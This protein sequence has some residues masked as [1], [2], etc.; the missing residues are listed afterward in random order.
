MVLA[1]ISRTRWAALGAAVAVSLGAGGIG[2]VDAA[3]G[4]GERTVFVPITPCRL[5]DTRPEFQVGS[6]NTPLGPDETY[7][8]AGLGA[9]GE[10][11]LPADAAGLV[12]NVTTVDA[13]LPTFVSVWPAGQPQPNASHLNPA[14]GEPP[15]PNAVTTD[16]GASGEFSVYNKQGSVHLF[17]DAVG[18][19]VDHHHDDRYYTKA[20]VYTQA[21]VDA[22]TAPEP[23]L[24][25]HPHI[26]DF[27]TPDTGTAQEAWHLGNGWEHTAGSAEPCLLAPI[28]DPP[29]G[30][31]INTLKLAYRA[32]NPAEVDITI[33]SVRN[34][35]GIGGPPTQI[36]SFV[37][38][39]EVLNGNLASQNRIIQHDRNEV[40]LGVDAGPIPG[41]G[42]DTM[43]QICT[44]NTLAI[45]SAELSYDPNIGLN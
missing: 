36:Y 44:A 38:E 5:F 34:S 31:R 32:F 19:Y 12:L 4:S 9:V 3:I 11:T 17:A 22:L 20:E 14:P 41:P 7:N 16:L 24:P 18:Y 2:L 1:Q 39:D 30:I 21:E 15:T 27:A 28:Y 35:G 26:L 37:N 45:L 13:S 8:V 40:P 6:R 42:Y 43:L 33:F 25:Y 10:C 23:F 29:A